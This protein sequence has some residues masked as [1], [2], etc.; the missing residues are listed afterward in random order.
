MGV[1]IGFIAGNRSLPTNF[2]IPAFAGMTELCKGL[3]P[4]S[5]LLLIRQTCACGAG[6][7]LGVA[8]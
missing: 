5:I 4:R 6:I 3:I 7:A 8:G 2:W 1:N